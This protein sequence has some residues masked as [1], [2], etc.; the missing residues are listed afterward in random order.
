MNEEITKSPRLY[1]QQS[2]REGDSLALT[3][4]QFHYLSNVLRKAEGAPIRLFNGRDGEFTGELSYK[5]KKEVCLINLQRLRNQSEDFQKIHLYFPLIK[6]E[7][8]AFMIEKA[9][10]LGVTDLHPILTERTTHAKQYRRERVES[11]IIEAAE[12]CER[13][14]IPNLY[15]PAPIEHCTFINPT[16]AAVERIADV[17]IFKPE[18]KLKKIGVC[19]GPEGGWTADEIKYLANQP[20]IKQTSL[21]S[22]ILRAETAALFMLSRLK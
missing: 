20:N 7:R 15:E 16:Y 19:I 17:P 2:L 1:C 10:E 4:E 12:Q 22:N 9:V 6:K 18:Q 3:K 8:L 21:G 5:S 11:H 13:M 14:T